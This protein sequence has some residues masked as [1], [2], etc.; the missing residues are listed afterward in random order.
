MGV[1]S[2]TEVNYSSLNSLEFTF[3]LRKC[4]YVLRFPEFDA[5]LYDYFSYCNGRW[6]DQFG[7]TIKT[8]PN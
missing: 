6:A 2:H 5:P 4:H 7:W 1:S 3:L 8:L